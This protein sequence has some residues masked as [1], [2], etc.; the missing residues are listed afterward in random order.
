VPARARWG[1]L[2]VAGPA[3]QRPTPTPALAAVSLALSA[4]AKFSARSFTKC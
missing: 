4:S 2:A 1:V 3:C